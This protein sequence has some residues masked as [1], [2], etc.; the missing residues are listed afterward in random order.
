MDVPHVGWPAGP[1]TFLL[2]DIEG[3]TAQWDD[4]PA[5]MAQALARHDL[6]IGDEVARAGGHLI[7]AK[8]EGDSTVSVFSRAAD[9][10]T[11]AIGVQRALRAEPWPGR[12]RLRARAAVHTGDAEERDGDYFGTTLNRAARLRNLAAGGQ[13]FLSATTADIVRGTLPEGASL[14]DLGERRVRGLR[15]VERVFAVDARGLTSTPGAIADGSPLVLRRART[16]LVGRTVELAELAD[17]TAESRLVTILGPGGVGKTRLVVELLDRVADRFGTD[18]WY[19]ELAPVLDPSLLAAA[20]LRS[21]S[22]APDD[23]GDDAATRL[24]E[25]IGDGDGLLVLDNCEHLIDSCAFLASGLLDA[26]PRLRIVVTSREALQVRGEH[27]FKLPTLDVPAFGSDPETVGGVD[28]VRLLQD[29]AAAAGAPLDVTDSTVGDVTAICRL[30][31][32]LPLAI[33]L[34]AARLPT[35]GLHEVAVQL[36]DQMGLLSGGP[37]D[38]EPRQQSLRAAL[39]WSH[40]LLSQRDRLAFRRLSVF[41]A[42][43][44][45]DAAE[46]VL[47]GEGLSPDEAGP[48]LD[49]LVA[50]SLVELDFASRRYRMLEPVRQ[51]AASWCASE[52]EAQAAAQRHAVWVTALARRAASGFLVDQAV[53]TDRL[54]DEHANI[55]RAV[56]WS[57]ACGDDAV[58]HIVAALASCWF[59]T[60]RPEAADWAHRAV[61]ASAGAPAKLRARVLFAAGQLAQ[62]RRQTIQDTNTTSAAGF[63]HAVAWLTEAEALFRA[64]DARRY[65]AWTLWWR[66]RALANSTGPGMSAG[67]ARSI[68]DEALGLFRSEGDV[69]GVGWC[70]NWLAMFAEDDGD[71]ALAERLLDEVV[72]LAHAS[73]IEN[74]LGEALISLARLRAHGEDHAGAVALVERAVAV[75][76]RNCDRWQLASTLLQLA[77]ACTSLGDDA[78]AT[79]ALRESIDIAHANRFD[80]IVGR[81]LWAL[82]RLLP[83]GPARAADALVRAWPYP[84]RRVW[85]GQEEAQR[86]L[87]ERVAVVGSV[88]RR[89]S[90]VDVLALA[91]DA[92]ELLEEPDVAGTG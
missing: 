2:T 71:W 82:A 30:L 88:P 5:A 54:E 37:R 40:G 9:A 72:E 70:L 87:L 79:R 21:V 77:N 18:C 52:G 41:D 48:A 51:Y 26:C 76:R 35:Q 63:E 80:E 14:V 86:R 74:F 67:F 16:R 7:K 29:R 61:T 62:H 20:V 84:Q 8:G 13:V 43:C 17:R 47:P 36:T 49:S 28:S 66:G 90:P 85:P 81:S 23:D 22:R 45:R 12:L 24:V 10:L 46:A 34:A 38:V 75:Y 78:G 32:G 69:L 44:T 89:V 50:R 33:E 1:V 73:G 19:V 58:L 27:R 64:L 68:F 60:G 39:D 6:L 55:A 83:A 56:E 25:V 57:F 65:L 59:F 53:W 91:G 31:D 42:G 3:S 11:A 15:R 4:H 92:L